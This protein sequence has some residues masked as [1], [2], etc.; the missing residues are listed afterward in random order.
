MPAWDLGCRL[1][2]ESAGGLENDAAAGLSARLRSREV[3]IIDDEE[4]VIRLTSLMV[5]RL[6]LVPRATVSGQ[7]GLE[8][9]KSEPGA[10]GAL[11]LDIMLADTNGLDVYETVRPLDR[12]L[13]IVLFSGYSS[14]INQLEGILSRDAR[15]RFLAKPFGAR[16]LRQVLE[17][18]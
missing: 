3:L 7:D 15:V 14:R 18:F 12:E 9:L 10:F 11:I 2:V 4:A 16:Q 17:G 1:L 5:Q 8:L 6:G 13:P